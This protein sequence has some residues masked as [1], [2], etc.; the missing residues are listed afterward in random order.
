MNRARGRLSPLAVACKHGN[1]DVFNLLIEHNADITRGVDACGETLLATAC[2]HGSID[3]AKALIALGE[4]TRPTH[5]SGMQ[6]GDTVIILDGEEDSGATV[7]HEND[8][9]LNH[10]EHDQHQLYLLPHEEAKGHTCDVKLLCGS[11]AIILIR[12][13]ATFTVHMPFC[14][15][16]L[17]GVLV[18]YI[19]H[20]FCAT[21]T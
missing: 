20:A 21:V 9:S 13:H 1:I 7:I 11:Y 19:R 6:I 3:V 10:P 18:L 12:V 17:W 4:D 14:L 8:R 15:T 2:E 16:T 5:P